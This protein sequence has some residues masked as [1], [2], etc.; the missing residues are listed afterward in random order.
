MKWTITYVTS[1]I[2]KSFK[3]VADSYGDAY[4]AGL[5][6]LKT[7]GINGVQSIISVN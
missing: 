7:T 4:H 6:K 1:G 5:A 3:V 2:I